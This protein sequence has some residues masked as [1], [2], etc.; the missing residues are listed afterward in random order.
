MSSIGEYLRAAREERK[1]PM[2]QVVRDTKI[3]ERYV[4]AMENGRFSLLPAP[5][6]AKGFLKIYAE[7]LGLDPR[8]IVEQYVQEHV[9]VIRQGL[10][11]DG[12]IVTPAVPSSWRSAAIGVVVAVVLIIAIVSGLKLWRSCAVARARRP[13]V[14]TEELETLPLPPLPQLSP[15]VKSPAAA[16]KP[17]EAEPKQKKLE[18][19]VGES[20]WMKVYGDGVLLFQGTVRKGKKEFWLAKESFDIR[21]AKP[22]MVD[23]SIDGKPL[24]KTKR[25][26]AQNVFIDK[27][28]KTVFY[29]GKMRSE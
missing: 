18:A 29:K 8:P 22:Q 12:E 26:S 5:A 6:Y 15:T 25:K 20:V 7:Y 21:V 28:G 10:P 16:P 27:N 17:Q 13:A 24:R 23:L 1:I 11:P 2:A 3:S 19:K 9:G 4:V 14:S